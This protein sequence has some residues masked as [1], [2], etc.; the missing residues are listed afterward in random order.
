MFNRFFNKSFGRLIV[1]TRE[2][3]G[4]TQASLAEELGVSAQFLGRVEAGKTRMPVA[5]FKR[6]VKY[7]GMDLE[8]IKKL[9]Q[10]SAANETARLLGL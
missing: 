3:K 10:R 7:L 2:A 4:L 9:A 5:R 1:S 6:S 8:L